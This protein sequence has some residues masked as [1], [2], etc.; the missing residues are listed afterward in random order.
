MAA[1]SDDVQSLVCTGSRV[2]FWL[3]LTSGL[4]LVPQFFSLPSGP[5]SYPVLFQS[6]FSACNTQSLV[7]I[8]Y[9]Y[10]PQLTHQHL[11][12]GKSSRQSKL[13]S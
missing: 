4:P 1:G 13:P 7:S 6:I 10:E 12:G 5:V 11:R 2:W 9:I 8:A 3:R